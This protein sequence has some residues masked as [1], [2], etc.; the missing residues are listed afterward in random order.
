VR[1]PPKGR[2]PVVPLPLTQGPNAA[3]DPDLHLSSLFATTSSQLSSAAG[4]ITRATASAICF[5]CDSSTTS[6]FLPLSTPITLRLTRT[7]RSRIFI[8]GCSVWAP[9]P[10]SFP[11]PKALD[12]DGNVAAAQNALAAIHVLYDW[13]WANAE[14]VCRHGVELRPGDAAA[15]QHLADYMSIQSRHD[16]AIA[17]SRKA[18]E[19]NPISRVSL[20]H[21]GSGWP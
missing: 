9:A 4:H 18:L 1:P 2:F 14:S 6:C 13:D 12:L 17:E 10:I 16:E 19:S 15:R 11:K 8:K 3:P 5:H 20:G 21:F 7:F